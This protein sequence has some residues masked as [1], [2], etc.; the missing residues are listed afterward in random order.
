M[1]IYRALD[2]YITSDSFELMWFP[3]THASLSLPLL[4]HYLSSFRRRSYSLPH[5]IPHW[6]HTKLPA[7]H[8]FFLLFLSL[9]LL[10]MM[11]WGEEKNPHKKFHN[12]YFESLFKSLIILP[13]P[14][15]NALVRLNGST[16]SSE[17]FSLIQDFFMRF[18]L[19]CSLFIFFW[20]YFISHLYFIFILFYIFFAISFF[21]EVK[22]KRKFDF[23]F[24]FTRILREFSR[25]E[26]I[27]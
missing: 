15:L 10:T 26:W 13:H 4:T 20:C 7:Y 17:Y 12:K 6:T 24:I 22:K 5:N 16:I 14:H 1:Y 21:W 23:N 11:W 2:Y 9:S 27:K 8:H 18:F 25:I 3:L 19:L